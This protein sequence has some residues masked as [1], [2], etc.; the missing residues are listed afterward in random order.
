[1]SFVV[2]KLQFG[3]T[4]RHFC[5]AEALGASISLRTGGVTKL[6]PNTGVCDRDRERGRDAAGSRLSS[7]RPRQK[8]KKEEEY[9][10]QHRGVRRAGK[11]GRWREFKT[12]PRVTL[13]PL[14]C[15]TL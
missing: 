9:V 6:I 15:S 13:D 11:S 7:S 2:Q 3:R 4:Q 14:H 8:K 5:T 1:M 10:G 12:C